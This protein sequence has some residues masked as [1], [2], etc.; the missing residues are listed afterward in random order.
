ME[1][2]ANNTKRTESTERTLVTL[3]T[4]SGSDAI[5]VLRIILFN[6]SPDHND[7]SFNYSAVIGDNTNYSRTI[8]IKINFDNPSIV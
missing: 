7:H 3:S 5:P 8:K 6:N 2:V 1:G 4:F